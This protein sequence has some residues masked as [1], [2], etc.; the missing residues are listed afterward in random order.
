MRTTN[1][2]TRRAAR[3]TARALLFTL[4]ALAA[5]LGAAACADDDGPTGGGAPTTGAEAYTDADADA[6]ADAGRRLAELE[7]REAIRD[8]AACYG[9][10]HDA[11]FFDL[12]GDKREAKSILETCF[13][14]GVRTKV[15]FFDAPEPAQT[16]EG[17]DSLVEFIAAFAL[18]NNY[19]SA[20][21]T[22]GNVHID[23]RADG[24][25]TMTTAG[26]TPHFIRPAGEGLEPSVDVITARYVD[27][28]RR[29]DDG[30][31]RTYAKELHIDA[32][33]RGSGLYPLAGS[34]P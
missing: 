25:A 5:P 21:N 18:A 14:A 23:L 1:D 24:T 30:R 9:R 31:W 17:L 19:T 26:A 22:P 33:W 16:L 11:I 10:G 8:V 29:G 12:R 15:Y 34:A 6:D 7:D 2:T 27:E 32:V 4:L 3:G 28:V 13:E 20:R